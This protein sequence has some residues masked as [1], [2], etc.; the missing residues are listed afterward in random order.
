MV[1]WAEVTNT[2]AEGVADAA[3]HPWHTRNTVPTVRTHVLRLQQNADRILSLERRR[4][5][6]KVTGARRHMVT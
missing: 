6:N 2:R 5:L 3:G 4:S 1:Q